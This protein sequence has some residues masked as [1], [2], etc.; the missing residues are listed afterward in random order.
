MRSP[1]LRTLIVEDEAVARE[2]LRR[3][4]ERAPNVRVV[5]EAGDAATA[6]RLVVERAPDIL[7][8]DIQLGGEDGFSLLSSLEPGAVPEVVFVTAFDEFAV[9][10]FRVYAV[11]FVVKPFDDDRLLSALQRAGAR[12]ASR[13]DGQ[14]PERWRDL[15]GQLE[16]RR[17]YPERLAVRRRGRVQMLA[18]A[19]ISWVDAARD[20]CVL[21]LR[22]GS[23]VP[24]RQPIGD[25]E[26]QLDPEQFVRVHRSTLVRVL[27]IRELS[28]RS[29]GDYEAVLNDGHR[30]N[31]SRAARSRLEALL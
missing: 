8:L 23:T 6:R 30:V 20:S 25:L 9:E 22:D 14:L 2:H 16:R 5:G 13:Q 4:A 11:D 31:V 12:I 10:A 7:L 28:L 27:D 17:A 19:E 3:V 26:T 29:Y 21:H 1:R 15:A 18:V 24:L